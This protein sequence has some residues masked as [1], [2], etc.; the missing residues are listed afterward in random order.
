M[1]YLRSNGI[2]Y[3]CKRPSVSNGYNLI[4][5]FFFFWNKGRASGLL[6]WIWNYQTACKCNL[7]IRLWQFFHVYCAHST[8]G[9]IFYADQIDRQF[10]HDGHVTHFSSP[11]ILLCQSHFHYSNNAIRLKSTND[12][13][14]KKLISRESTHIFHL[15]VSFIYILSIINWQV[16]VA[17]AVKLSSK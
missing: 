17:N 9:H 7:K 15:L 3:N 1:I 13:C 12:F 2:L 4:F 14:R 5:F 10:S 11:I 8:I 6:T 16:Y